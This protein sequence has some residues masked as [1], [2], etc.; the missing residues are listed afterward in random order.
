MVAAVIGSLSNKLFYAKCW[1]RYSHLNKSRGCADC[2]NRVRPTLKSLLHGSRK[3]EAQAQSTNPLGGWAG[4][5]G[6]A[7]GSTESAGAATASELLVP[8]A[9][10][11]PVHFATGAGSGSA[12]LRSRETEKAKRHQRN[13]GGL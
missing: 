13:R 10:V 3:W 2:I 8:A 6:D 7:R 12:K 1:N 4:T 5:T 11:L 9:E